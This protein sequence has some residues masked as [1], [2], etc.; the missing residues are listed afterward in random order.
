MPPT[1]PVINKILLSIFPFLHFL[2]VFGAYSWKLSVLMDSAIQKTHK[3]K[4]RSQN[5][6]IFTQTVGDWY[7]Y[8]CFLQSAQD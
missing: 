8:F 4:G 5:G 3:V 7:R 1:K 6:A 2:A